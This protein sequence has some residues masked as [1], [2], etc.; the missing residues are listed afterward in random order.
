MP[1]K[2][3][4]L[5]FFDWFRSKRV[6]FG[7]FPLAAVVLHQVQQ[8]TERMCIGGFY[9]C[10]SPNTRRKRNKRINKLRVCV[11]AEFSVR[12]VGSGDSTRPEKRC[13]ANEGGSVRDSEDGALL[14]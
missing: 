14:P 1:F 10:G 11:S 12:L 5:S 8:K 4:F 9:V 2:S 3:G 6:K 13:G 7:N